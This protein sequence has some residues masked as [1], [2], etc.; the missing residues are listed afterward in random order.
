MHITPTP[1]ALP[2]PSQNGLSS[3]AEPYPEAQHHMAVFLEKLAL[4]LNPSALTDDRRGSMVVL[5]A[6]DQRLALSQHGGRMAPP[7]GRGS[8][9][10]ASVSAKAAQLVV[11]PVAHVDNPEHSLVLNPEPG[12]R[13]NPA[14]LEFA[15]LLPLVLRGVARQ[16]GRCS[17]RAARRQSSDLAVEKK[18]NRD[19]P[20]NAPQRFPG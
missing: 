9:A 3:S 20:E 16:S 12:A 6:G 4:E 11:E 19:I 13:R 2:E 7:T 5:L 10:V 14:L 17:S 1:N 15:A 8:D 18:R